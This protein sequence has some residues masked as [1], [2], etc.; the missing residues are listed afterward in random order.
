MQAES[1]ATQ[2]WWT[3]PTAGFLLLITLAMFLGTGPERALGRSSYDSTPDGFRAAY[4][5]LEEL[6]YP[7]RR[8]RRLMAGSIRVVLFPLSAGK[9]GMKETSAVH[10]WVQKGGLLILADDQPEFARAFG[11]TV[12]LQKLTDAASAEPVVL[13]GRTLRVVGGDTFVA[14]SGKPSQFWAQAGE[15]PLV[16]QVQVGSGEVW[17]I[18]RPEFARNQFI[19]QADNAIIWCRLIEAALAVRPGEVAVDEFFHGLRD[20]P[21]VIELLVTPPLLWVTLQGLALLGLL[22]WHYGPR[23]GGLRGETVVSRR[24]KE[25]YLDAMAALLE[26]KRDYDDAF[27]TARDELVQSIERELGLPVGTRADDL[28]HEAA[29]RRPIQRR[30]LLRLLSNE[31]LPPRSGPGAFVKAMSEV[32]TARQE[33]FRG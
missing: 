6:K 20:R 9:E 22:L 2:L 12:E 17:F 30:L 31:A 29:R 3:V 21:G 1:K 8:S 10:D 23:F 14:V 19:G 27:R 5:L 15:R 13:G 32:E 24:S 26:R 33:F 25:E 4:L 28:V 11:L 7:V 16:T 18:N